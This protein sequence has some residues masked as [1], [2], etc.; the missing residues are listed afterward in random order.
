LIPA[1]R[2]ARPRQNGEDGSLKFS[3]GTTLG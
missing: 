2:L 3:H 1:Q